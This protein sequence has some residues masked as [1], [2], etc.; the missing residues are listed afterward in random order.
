MEC[1]VKSVSKKSVQFD[2]FHEIIIIPHKDDYRRY[3]Q[4][5][6]YNA[7][8]LKMFSI[9]DNYRKLELLPP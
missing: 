7:F 8:E 4:Y 9:L 2:C 6:W 3:H 1:G 5:L